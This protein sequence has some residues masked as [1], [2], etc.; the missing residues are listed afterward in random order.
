M[1]FRRVDKVDNYHFKCYWSHSTDKDNFFNQP[2]LK[3]CICVCVY[4]CVTMYLRPV[5]FVVKFYMLPQIMSMC[6]N[7]S[8]TTNTVIY[9]NYYLEQNCWETAITLKIRVGS[10]H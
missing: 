2:F 7:N 8:V 5:Q 9:T 3:T 1:V 6:A 10:Q 4:L